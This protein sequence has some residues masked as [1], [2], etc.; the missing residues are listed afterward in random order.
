MNTVK[1]ELDAKLNLISKMEQS[2]ARVL[3]A[4]KIMEEADKP[5]VFRMAAVYLPLTTD[6][7]KAMKII[8]EV[9]ESKGPDFVDIYNDMANEHGKQPQKHPSIK[10][11]LE[12]FKAAQN[13][14]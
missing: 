5:S 11:T 12:A 3:L 13:T 9:A 14:V 10:A 6:N 2:E 4:K 7:F 8:R 1:I